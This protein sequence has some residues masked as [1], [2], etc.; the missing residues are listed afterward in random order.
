MSRS[1]DTRMSAHHSTFKESQLFDWE[2]EPSQERPSAFFDETGYDSLGVA[3][4][5]RRKTHG[6]G[7]I[8]FVAAMLLGIG[9]AAMIAMKRLLTT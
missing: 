8:F 3:R 7:L 9:I 5:R 4:V 1:E 2:A 6:H